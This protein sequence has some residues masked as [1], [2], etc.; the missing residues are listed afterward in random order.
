ME[1]LISAAL[2]SQ[3][4]IADPSGIAGNAGWFGAGLLGLVLAWLFLVYLPSRDKRDAE[5]DKLLLQVVTEKDLAIAGTIKSFREE[6]AAERQSCERN[7]ERIA[8]AVEALAD[9]IKTG[10]T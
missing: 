8:S 10:G 5:K 4:P 7:T 3:G 2:L 9:Q 1:W 6:M